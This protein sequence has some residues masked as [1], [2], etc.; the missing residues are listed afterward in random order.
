MAAAPDD[1]VTLLTR[2]ARLQ[3]TLS[4]G[5]LGELGLHPGQD[6]LLRVLWE[7][8]GRTQAELVEE[9]AVEAPTVTKM[10]RRLEDAGF[11]RRRAHPTDR[12]STQVFL[13]ATGRD[14][15]RDVQRV[16]SRVNRRSTAGLSPRQE[17]TLRSLLDR[18][19]VNLDG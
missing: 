3:R 17:A 13:T 11:V 6:S 9:L 12:R 10:V 16:R 14:V 8:D 1:V 2:A 7:N 15:R 5:L 19:T 4:A 18:V